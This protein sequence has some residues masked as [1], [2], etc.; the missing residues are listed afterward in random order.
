MLLTL[1][2][3]QKA[4]DDPKTAEEYTL[5]ALSL[6]EKNDERLTAA[7]ANQ[8]LGL[9]AAAR[10]DVEQTDRRFRAAIKILTEARSNE[11]LVDCLRSYSQVLEARGDRDAALDQLKR[12]VE[13]GRRPLPAVE[14]DDIRAGWRVS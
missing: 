6:A 2:D 1:S 10:N 14:E 11:R 5:Q 7:K 4:R 13:V 8:S 3:L 12:A 9:L